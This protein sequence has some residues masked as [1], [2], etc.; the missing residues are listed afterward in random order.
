MNCAF[1]HAPLRDGDQFC[2]NCGRPVAQPVVV[3]EPSVQ[4]TITQSGEPPKK[5]LTGWMLAVII[6]VVLVLCCGVTAV[7]GF[8]LFNDSSQASSLLEEN[9]AI[10]QMEATVSAQATQLALQIQEQDQAAQQPQET[11]SEMDGPTS[12]N[13]PNVV[14]G[15]LNIWFDDALMQGVRT[16]QVEPVP[17]GGYIPWGY[18][19]MH[20]KLEVENPKGSIHLVPV[21]AYIP[22]GEFANDLI[23][24]LQFTLDNRP[25]VA[26]WGCIPTWDF[27]CDHQEMNINVSYFDFQ[28]GSGIRSVTVYA[29]QDT[30]AINNESLDY[31]YNGLTEDGF[32]YVYANFDLRHTSL[33]EDDWTLPLEVRMDT[34]G[35]EL[36]AYVIENADILESWPSGYEPQLEV[37]DAV[38][39]SLRVELE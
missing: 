27:P 28:N 38:I 23:Q 20:I 5:R 11:E 30:S 24:E 12:S 7:G 6:V 39:Q 16:M 36:Q 10:V 34:T 4:G 35:D 3:N 29:P 14:E 31:Y 8:F 15:S 1:C 21:N 18:A 19:P 9:G 22:M 25:A 13:P 37:L 2:E 33:T 32:F 17:P 26:S